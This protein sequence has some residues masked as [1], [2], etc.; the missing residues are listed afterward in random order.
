MSTPW[1]LLRRIRI[2]GVPVYVHWSVLVVI[3]LFCF[4]SVY[5][6]IYAVVAAASYLGVIVIHEAGHAWV[7]QRLGCRVFAIRI[8]WLHG[9]CEIEDNIYSERDDVLIAWAGVVAQLVVAL[10]VIAAE[11]AFEG[12]DL[13]VAYPA[14][15][16][17]GHVN[18]ATALL[19]LAPALGLDG[20]KAWRAVPLMWNWWTARGA[21]RRVLGQLKR[22][23]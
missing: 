13:G 5:S 16:L 21:T 4:M 11:I 10:P 20:Q 15:V 14:V 17:L 18:L 12:Y 1:L 6:V 23:K 7:A 19:N 8:A 22:R 2:L 3:G 9:S